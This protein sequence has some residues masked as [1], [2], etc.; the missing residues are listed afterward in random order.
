ME[1]LS[2][3]LT[4]AVVEGR[5][6]G[7]KVCEKAPVISHL[8]FADESFL[9]FKANKN[10]SLAIKSILNKYE[11]MSGQAVNYQKFHVFSECKTR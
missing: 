7:C 1:E 2:N 11:E 8:L 10:E 5:V 4:K 3:S 6:S 9:F